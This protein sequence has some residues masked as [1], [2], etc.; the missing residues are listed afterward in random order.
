MLTTEQAAKKLKLSRRRVIALITSDK[1]PASKFGK[2]YVIQ[3]SDLA[4]LRNRKP[5][6]PKKKA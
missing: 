5:G 6:R 4:K 2:S 3:E 1:L